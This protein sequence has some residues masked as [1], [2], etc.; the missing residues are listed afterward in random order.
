MEGD[1]CIKL[2]KDENGQH[3]YIP[4]SWV[5]STDDGVVKIDRPGEEAM[6]KWSTSPLH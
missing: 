2:K 5:E 1:N 3:H 4:T 6:E